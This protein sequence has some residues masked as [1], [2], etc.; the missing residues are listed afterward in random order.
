MD[1]PNVYPEGIPFTDARPPQDNPDIWWDSTTLQALPG[2]VM[3][4]TGGNFTLP[5][6]QVPPVGAISPQ[7][8]SE[9]P[10]PE[11]Y[12]GEA[13]ESYQIRTGP[14]APLGNTFDLTQDQSLQDGSLPNQPQV[15]QGD[16][17]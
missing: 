14:V 5:N 12:Q 6:G 17:V 4:V 9:T 11:G 16:P 10:L 7:M 15:A 3:G 1:P 2:G 8:I 13:P